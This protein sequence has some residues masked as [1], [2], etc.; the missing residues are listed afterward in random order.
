LESGLLLQLASSKATKATD[1]SIP[2]VA[3][4]L[5]FCV[6]LEMGHFRRANR[7]PG[8]TREVILLVFAEY[9]MHPLKIDMSMRHQ[10]SL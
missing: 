2:M 6:R 1:R 4:Y 8:F 5:C 3:V 10:L 9:G 7:I